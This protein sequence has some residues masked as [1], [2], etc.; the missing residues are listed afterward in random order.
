MEVCSLLDFILFG[1]D[2]REFDVVSIDIKLA[3]PLTEEQINRLGAFKRAGAT[4]NLYFSDE[5]RNAAGTGGRRLRLHS[6][7]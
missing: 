3:V 2:D 5:E 7:R 1:D 6:G 4:L